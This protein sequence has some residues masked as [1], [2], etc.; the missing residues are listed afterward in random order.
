MKETKKIP[1]HVLKA[2][3]QA[4]EHYE[5]PDYAFGELLSAWRVYAHKSW[6]TGAKG[7]LAVDDA[8]SFCEY[9]GYKLF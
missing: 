3:L 6:Y 1:L 9:A 2:R 5:N 4:I 7:W 8:L